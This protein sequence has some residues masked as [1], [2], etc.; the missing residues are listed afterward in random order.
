MDKVGSAI[1]RAQRRETGTSVCFATANKYGLFLL[2]YRVSFGQVG[3]LS[4][5][6]AD[7]E[8]TLGQADRKY[9]RKAFL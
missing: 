1:K 3:C 4:G 6:T 2:F 5:A 7:G 9:L 8:L